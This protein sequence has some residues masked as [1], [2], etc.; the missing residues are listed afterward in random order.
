MIQ[1]K[2]VGCRSCERHWTTYGIHSSGNDGAG[3]A[4]PVGADSEKPPVGILHDCAKRFSEENACHGES[5]RWDT[6]KDNQYLHIFHGEAGAVL[7]RPV[8]LTDPEVPA[9]AAT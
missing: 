9:I 4:G 6:G 2:D 7:A 5:V 3:A 1:V 8:R